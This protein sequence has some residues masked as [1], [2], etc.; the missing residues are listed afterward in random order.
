MARIVNTKALIQK[1]A[2]HINLRYDMC[3]QNMDDIYS[4]SQNSY[5]MICNSF[6]FGYMQG[7]KAARAEI[8]K[9]RAAYAK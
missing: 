8:K 7:A 9:G 2:S 5:E 4:M 3:T 6:R 1:S